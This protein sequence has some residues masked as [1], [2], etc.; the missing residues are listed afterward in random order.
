M[1]MILDGRYV[2]GIGKAIINPKRRAFT[3]IVF[4]AETGWTFVPNK[5]LEFIVF[6]IFP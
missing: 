3:L 5:V 1:A 4:P 6:S 2:S